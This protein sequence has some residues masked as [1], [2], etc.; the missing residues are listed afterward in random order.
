MKN[1]GWRRRSCGFSEG[2]FVRVGTKGR[3]KK[4]EEE[5]KRKKNEGEEEGKEKKKTKW[6]KHVSEPRLIDG[7]MSEPIFL[8][9]GNASESPFSYAESLGDSNL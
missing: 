5:R 2:K 6:C 3:R 7:R 9:R 8:P 4:K 1:E